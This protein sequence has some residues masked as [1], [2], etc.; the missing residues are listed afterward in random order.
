MVSRALSL[1]AVTLVIGCFTAVGVRAQEN[2]DAGKTP[3]QIFS[4]TCNACHKSA[5]GLLKTVPA[6]SLSG[7]L[8]QHYTTSSN[9]ANV[10][11]SFLISNGAADQRFQAKDQ[12]RQKD[13]AK[14]AKQEAATRPTA[15]QPDGQRLPRPG[16]T[17]DV[18]RPDHG[19][20]QA[21]ID[22]KQ[23][24]KQKQGKKGRPAE[25]P[26]K[27]EE[28]A[29]TEQP[30][31]APKTETAKGD[32]SARPESKSESGKSENAKVGVPKE[33]VGEPPPTRPDPVPAVTPAPA[34]T[35]EAPGSSIVSV[36]PL[37]FGSA[38]PPVQAAQPAAP[39]V[40]AAPSLPPVPPAGPPVPPISQ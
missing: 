15:Q 25:E 8:R 40:T 35:A 19:P 32:D 3:A 34:A 33:A 36:A 4:G 14:D 18:M 24:T 22:A 27:A 23:G 29:K 2:L 10:L 11:A 28:P 39:A 17:T 37:D 31:E 21:A 30:S 38:A 26:P 12:P 6:S 7:F 9:M 13:G 20:A 5:R 16:E 1:A